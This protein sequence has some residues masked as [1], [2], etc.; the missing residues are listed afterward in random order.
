MADALGIAALGVAA[1]A[2]AIAQEAKETAEAAV[3]GNVALIDA[4]DGNK[5][6]TMA[7][8]VSG[9]YPCLTLTPVTEEANA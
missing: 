9:G 6:Y 3:A 2:K 8:S 1:H 5:V 4:D 7:W